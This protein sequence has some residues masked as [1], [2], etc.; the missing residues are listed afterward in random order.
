MKQGFSWLALWLGPLWFLANT[1]WLTFFVSAGLIWVVPRIVNVVSEALAWDANISTSI[2]LS[3]NLL[4]WLLIGTV[5]NFLLGE[6]LK[7]R[8]YHLKSIVQAKSSNDAVFD[9]RE[10]TGH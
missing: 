4:V 2:A 3:I 8:G 1:M 9:F 7:L 5:A 10:K 6:D